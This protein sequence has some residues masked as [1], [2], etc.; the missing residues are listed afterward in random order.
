MPRLRAVMILGFGVLLLTGCTRSLNPLPHETAPALPEFEI[1]VAPLVASLDTA[2]PPTG[3]AQ[4][5]PDNIGCSLLCKPCIVWIC[6]NNR[7]VQRSVETPKEICER[8]R[9][10]GGPRLTACPRTSE[11]FC[12]AECSVCF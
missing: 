4:P 5:R 9:P 2:N 6:Q 10:G 3:C 11:G 1:N 12:A 8:R 7:W